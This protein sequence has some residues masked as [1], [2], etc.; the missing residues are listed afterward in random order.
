V[1]LLSSP[2]RHLK[3][4]VLLVTPNAGLNAAFFNSAA[5]ANR[6]A[7][8][9]TAPVGAPPPAPQI[10]VFLAMLLLTEADNSAHAFR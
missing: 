4:L 5:P 10:H 1:E 7:V 8:F 3:R 2:L 6:Q 9:S